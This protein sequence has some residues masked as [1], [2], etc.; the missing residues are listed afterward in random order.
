[1]PD[2]LVRGLVRVAL[3]LTPNWHPHL[4]ELLTSGDPDSALPI[5]V[6]TSEPV[7]PW[8][9]STV[10]L[11]GDA[12]HTMTPGRG[13]GANTALRDARLLCREL[14]RAAAGDKTFGVTSRVL[15][16]RRKFVDDFHTYEGDED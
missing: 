12:I 10:T 13:V 5:K 1:M 11:L 4:R 2:L 15:R 8:K 6:A 16:L 3:E 7:P 14:T 9:S